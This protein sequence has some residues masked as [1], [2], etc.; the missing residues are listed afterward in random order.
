M[1][2]EYSAPGGRRRASARTIKR[3]RGGAPYPE[4]S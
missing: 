2:D 3:T 1:R 4:L